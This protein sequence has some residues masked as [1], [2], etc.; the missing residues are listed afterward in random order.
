MMSIHLIKEY[1]CTDTQKKHARNVITIPYRDGCLLFPSS[2]VCA[3][4]PDVPRIVGSMIN[5]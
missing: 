2:R 1:K 4:M 5:T 3:G